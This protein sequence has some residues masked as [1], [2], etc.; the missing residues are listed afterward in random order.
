MC[1]RAIISE[2]VALKEA[3]ATVSLSTK[4]SPKEKKTTC[5]G[6][7]KRARG[8][9]AAEIR[10][11]RKGLT[12]WLGT[13]SNPEDAVRAYD[14]AAREVRGSKAK[15]NFPL[16]AAAPGD[17]DI[18]QRFSAL[19]G[20]LELEPENSSE[21]PYHLLRDFFLARLGWGRECRINHI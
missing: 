19:E 1:R 8:L 4:E 18:K 14:S 15:L 5:R 12:V 6:V 16:T 2:F 7:R 11:P 10:D 17:Y 9:W 21:D 3:S 13:Y 20:I